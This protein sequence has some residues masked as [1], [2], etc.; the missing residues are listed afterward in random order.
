MAGEITSVLALGRDSSGQ[1]SYG[2]NTI[3]SYTTG[4]DTNKTT[5]TSAGGMS[6][7]EGVEIGAAVLSNVLKS[8]AGYQAAKK[9]YSI[10]RQNY[11]NAE[12]A[13]ETNIASLRMQ[14]EQRAASNRAQIGAGGIKSDSFADVMQAN[15][16]IE[17]NDIAVMRANLREQMYQDLRQSVKDKYK[18]KQQA[19]AGAIG[20]VAGAAAGAMT[21]S[22]TAAIA[23]SR[24]GGS[25]GQAFGG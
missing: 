22:P 3:Q 9:N 5:S 1:A 19:V 17:E 14:N 12:R 15:K 18:A 6:V 4:T 25:L 11:F 8:V 7:G 10:L 23:L 2:T 13:M 16:I 21:G 20:F 24:A